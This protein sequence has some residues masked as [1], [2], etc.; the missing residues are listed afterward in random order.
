MFANAK[1]GNV[2]K[3]SLLEEDVNT[4]SKASARNTLTK[5]QTTHFTKRSSFVVC[6]RFLAFTR[7]IRKEGI[8]FDYS[9]FS[10]RKLTSIFASSILL[11]L[12]RRLKFHTDDVTHRDPCSV[13]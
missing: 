4:E 3:V 7:K 12:K 8:H 2:S 6:M 10:R 5:H 13:S 9:T 11:Q 1:K